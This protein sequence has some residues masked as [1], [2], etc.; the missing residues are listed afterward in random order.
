M[1]YIYKIQNKINQKVYVGKTEREDPGIRWKEHQYNMKSLDLPLYRALRQYGIEN[2]DFSI[3]EEVPKEQLDE[4]EIYWIEQY[5]SYKGEGYNC[6]GGGEGGIL[7]MDE[8]ITKMIERYQNG[9]R[10]DKLCKEFHHDYYSVKARFEQR[11]IKIDTHAGPKKNAKLVA[12]FNPET[13]ELVTIYESVSAAARAICPPGRNDKAIRNHISRYKD[14]LSISHGYQ[15]KT[16]NTMPDIEEAYQKIQ[17]E[18]D[19]G[20]LS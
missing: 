13:K 5:N 12:A 14:T 16:K 4:R 10:I 15:W 2:F 19:G 7:D 6:T 1:G 11:G 20:G 3:I 17:E 9:E 8:D 18:L